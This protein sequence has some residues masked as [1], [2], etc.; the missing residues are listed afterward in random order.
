MESL[1]ENQIRP[2]VDQILFFR[3]EGVSDPVGLKYYYNPCYGFS[4][5]TGDCSKGTAVSPVA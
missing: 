3:F 1:S 4:L 2:W 5:G